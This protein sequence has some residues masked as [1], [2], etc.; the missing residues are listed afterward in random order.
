VAGALIAMPDLTITHIEALTCSVPLQNGVSQGLGRAV[1]R[2]AVL[3]K[4]TV[5]GALTGYGEA[6]NGQAPLA[7]A[8]TVDTTLRDLLTG[9]DAA[10]TSRIWARF[11]DRVLANHGTCAACVFAMSGIDVA[12]WDINGKALGL[13]LHRLLGGSDQAVPGPA[14]SARTGRTPG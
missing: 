11:E 1:R 4:V 8:H 14:P 7:I 2:D 5:A 3:V 6:H 13:P 9:Q 10:E 12:L